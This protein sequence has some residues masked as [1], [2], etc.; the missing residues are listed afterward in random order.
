MASKNFIVKKVSIMQK[1]DRNAKKKGRNA[2]KGK[3]EKTFF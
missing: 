2:K 3:N 1:K